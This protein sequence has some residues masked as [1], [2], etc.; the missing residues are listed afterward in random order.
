MP[1]G[2]GLGYRR[3]LGEARAVSV[4]ATPFYQWT[5]VS[6]VEAA[7]GEEP[8]L[9]GNLF[10]VSLGAEVLLTRRIGATLGYEL[11]ATAEEGRPGQTGG[12]F[13]A[14]VSFVF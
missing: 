13:G 10:R 6:G 8:E 1:L 4:F 14:G 12:I 7:E 9:D 11:G 2:L 5:R 3:R